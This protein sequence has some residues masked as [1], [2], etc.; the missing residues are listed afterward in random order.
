[1]V[2]LGGN[3]LT[4]RAIPHLVG[5]NVPA[6]TAA[7]ASNVRWLPDCLAMFG[8]PD[9][10]VILMTAVPRAR[11]SGTGLSAFRQLSNVLRDLSDALRG[12]ATEYAP[13]CVL[14][15]VERLLG[16]ERLALDN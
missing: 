11:L 7:V 8:A 4:T 16:A 5:D 10:T 15:D 2:S 6:V 12:V 13:R 9:T 14:L 1:M 3:A